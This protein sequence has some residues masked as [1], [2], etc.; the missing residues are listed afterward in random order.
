[1]VSDTRKRN[2]KKNA[3][4]EVARLVR[5]LTEHLKRKKYLMRPRKTETEMYFHEKSHA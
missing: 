1:M 2:L 3:V 4:V 5:E